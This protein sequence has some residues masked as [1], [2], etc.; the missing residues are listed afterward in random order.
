MSDIIPFSFILIHLTQKKNGGRGRVW[1]VNFSIM[2]P[3]FFFSIMS[4]K[5][6]FPADL[7]D[8]A[9]VLRSSISAKD[10]LAKLE[11]GIQWVEMNLPAA[12]REVLLKSWPPVFILLWFLT[13]ECLITFLIKYW[14]LLSVITSIFWGLRSVFLFT[15]DLNADLPSR[16]SEHYFLRYWCPRARI[17]FIGSYQFLFNF[18]G[19]MAGW[20]CLYALLVR[21]KHDDAYIFTE[22]S[23]GDVVLF[24]FSL[25]GL[26]GHLPQVTY[27]FVGAVSDITKRAIQ[28]LT[29]NTDKDH[30]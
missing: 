20:M 30:E 18:I 26:T 9:P 12:S 29:W 6:F 24:I 27:G 13:M 3:K 2:S 7:S 23:W 5:F 8:E 25:I 14:F 15:T 21:I 11:A 22:F 16:Q 17:F 1:E 4:P 19:S 28:K 10:V